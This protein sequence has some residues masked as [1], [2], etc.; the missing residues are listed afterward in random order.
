MATTITTYLSSVYY[1]DATT[2]PTV[3]P[4]LVTANYTTVCDDPDDDIL[5]IVK[6]DSYSFGEND[7]VSGQPELVQAIWNA[8][9]VSPKPPVV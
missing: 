8:V 4:R 5:A 2:S 6:S 9:F 3:Q 7:D 1:T